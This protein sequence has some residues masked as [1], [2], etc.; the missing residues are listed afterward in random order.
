MCPL[1]IVCRCLFI[2]NQEGISKYE[3]KIFPVLLLI[4]EEFSQFPID[5]HKF[6]ERQLR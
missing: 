2:N 3:L 6:P 1:P 4:I 5:R